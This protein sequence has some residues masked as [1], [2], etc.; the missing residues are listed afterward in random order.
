MRDIVIAGIGQTIVGEHWDLSLRELAFQAIQA[1]LLDAVGLQPQALYAGNMLAPSLSH[2]THLGVLL[3]DFS[4]L[5][6]IE[7][8]SIEASGAS[9]AAALRQAYLAIASGYIQT[10]LVVGV[11]KFTDQIGSG[12]EEALATA[13]DSDFEAVHGQTPTGQAAMLMRRYFHEHDLPPN[14]LS[15]FAL[16]AHD[17]ASTNPYAMY[18][19]AISLATYQDAEMVS[20]PLNMFDLAPMAD[21]AAAILLTRSDLLPANFPHPLVCISGSANVTDS[22]A[23]HDRQD[24]LGFVAAGLSISKALQQAG[25]TLE[26]IDL[27]EY[28]DSYSIYAA[29]TLE[30]SGLVERGQAW[31]MA[32]DD[33]LGLK[34][35]LPCGTFG[36]LKAR[37]NP[38][39]ASGVYQG[40]EATLQLRGGAGANQVQGACHALI[41]SLG[42]PASIAI[43]HVL[44]RVK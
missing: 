35:S 24:P 21:G 11:E 33:R 20:E 26:D 43:S 15:G 13:T 22:L 32:R 28:H 1:A 18:H 27:F 30:A 44:E 41:Q 5:K 23:L 2:Q 36:G 29:L 10:A 25:I 7:A 16:N 17:H 39:G 6:G 31:Q 38:G 42:G 9:G 8:A 19:K 14:A 40:V 34:G 4:G 12:T 3:A 37:G